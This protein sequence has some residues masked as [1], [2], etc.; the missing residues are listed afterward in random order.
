MDEIFSEE[1]RASR[2]SGDTA[3][4]KHSRLPDQVKSV[5]TLFIAR[6]W[7]VYMPYSHCLPM[8]FPSSC[9]LPGDSC[10]PY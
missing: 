4:V 5:R 1:E 6:W 8:S 2:F 3:F 9:T 10:A 7:S